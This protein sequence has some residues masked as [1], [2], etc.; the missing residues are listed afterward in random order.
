MIAEAL[1]PLQSKIDKQCHQNNLLSARLQ[2]TE[3]AI[4]ALTT[5]LIDVQAPYVQEMMNTVLSEYF[6]S[7]VAMGFDP[8]T[9]EFITIS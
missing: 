1:R 9:A 3:K 7:N 6:E 4:F 8:S 5:V 2:N